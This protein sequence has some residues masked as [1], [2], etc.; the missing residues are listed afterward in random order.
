MNILVTI[1][2]S[3]FSLPVMIFVFFWAG[4]FAANRIGYDMGFQDGWKKRLSTMKRWPD[5]FR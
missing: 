1:M 2:E 4:V 5:D 3:L